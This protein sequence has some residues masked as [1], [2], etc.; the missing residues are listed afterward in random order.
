M[1][2]FLRTVVA[3]RKR[4]GN[5]SASWTFLKLWWPGTESNHRHADFQS[6]A[7]PTE[8]PGH[9][10]RKYIKGD[11]AAQELLAIFLMKRSPTPCSACFS[12]F[13]LVLAE[14]HAKLFELPV[15]VR[16]L[17]SRLLRHARHAAV[18]TREV[19]LEIRALEGIACIAQWNVEGGG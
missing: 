13:A 14:V 12:G 7:L 11:Y 15:K 19:I 9:E 6:A 18:F 1:V 5:L 2:P 10:E 16:A 8:L 4:P 3:Q 17:Q